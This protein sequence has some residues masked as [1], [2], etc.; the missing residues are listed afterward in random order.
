M[1]KFKDLEQ[2]LSNPEYVETKIYLVESDSVQTLYII[3]NDHCNSKGKNI[4][5][6]TSMRKITSMIQITSIRK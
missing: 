3:Y 1:T 5:K 6:I 4:G 2:S